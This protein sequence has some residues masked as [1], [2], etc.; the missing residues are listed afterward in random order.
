MV[1]RGSELFGN[2]GH[3]RKIIVPFPDAAGK[4]AESGQLRNLWIGDSWDGLSLCGASHDD[5]NKNVVTDVSG[6]V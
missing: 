3:P 4:G 5:V 1:E 6:V 2:Q